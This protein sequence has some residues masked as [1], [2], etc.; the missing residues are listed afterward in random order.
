[1][2]VARTTTTPV[3]ELACQLLSLQAGGVSHGLSHGRPGVD[4]VGCDSEAGAAVGPA[5]VRFRSRSLPA[6]EKKVS[7]RKLIVERNDK[8]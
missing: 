5:A 8:R 3:R 7:D 4:S 1:M 6:E 2:S